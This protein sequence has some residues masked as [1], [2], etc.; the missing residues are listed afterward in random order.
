LKS[1]Y[2]YALYLLISAYIAGLI[3]L[4]WAYTRTLFEALVP[5]NLILTAT[6]LFSFHLDWSRNFYIFIG[7]SFLGGFGIEALGVHTKVI[8]GEYWYE[9]TLG[10][11]LIDVPYLIGLNWV[12]LLYVCGN[13]SYHLTKSLI[14]RILL[15]SLLMVFLDYWI[16]P[17][18]MKHHFWNW[19]NAT[20]PL[21][22]YLAWGLVS[23][24]LLFFYFKLRF[25]KQNFLA[26]P[27]YL[28]QL[29]FFMLHNLLYFFDF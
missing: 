25:I 7:I 14:L 6:L 1:R 11:K 22:N 10:W 4:Q 18:A 13:I 8:F 21:Q 15:G 3:G 20:V 9:T 5:F 27:V 2:I 12:V 17:V 24:F 19:A 29:L 16:E 26:L 23:A 28:A